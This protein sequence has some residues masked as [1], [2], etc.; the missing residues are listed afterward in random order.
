[1]AELWSVYMD[2]VTEH[3][4]ISPGEF[5]A[6]MLYGRRADDSNSDTADIL[7]F[8]WKGYFWRKD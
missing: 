7:T 8:A 3:P 6:F 2:G 1:M 5:F 4:I